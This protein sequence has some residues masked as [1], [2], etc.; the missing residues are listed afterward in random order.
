LTYVPADHT[1]SLAHPRAA[2][3]SDRNIVLSVMAALVNHMREQAAAADAERKELIAETLHSIQ[4][5]I[6][7]RGIASDEAI[8][9]ALLAAATKSEP[10]YTGNATGEIQ[11]DLL[12]SLNQ[13]VLS[14]GLLTKPD[15]VVWSRISGALSSEIGDLGWQISI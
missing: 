10:R 14:A 1:G 5:N 9:S 3:D 15:P 11:S 12:R 13:R 7:S 6:A 8:G 4:R 2:A